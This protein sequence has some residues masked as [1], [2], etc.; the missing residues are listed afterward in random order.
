MTG[1]NRHTYARALTGLGF[2][3]DTLVSL[4]FT[5]HAPTTD[6]RDTVLLVNRETTTYLRHRLI[7]YIPIIVTI[8]S[9]RRVKPTITDV[10]GIAEALRHVGR[11]F[12]SEGLLPGSLRLYACTHGGADLS[13]MEIHR[14][15]LRHM[16]I[17]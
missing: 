15:T 7:P 13:H 8:L 6:K 3:R 9:I 14:Y 2:I 16:E 1:T 4:S 10:T 12:G 11:H 17:H 5:S